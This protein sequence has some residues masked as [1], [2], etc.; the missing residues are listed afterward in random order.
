KIKVL[1]RT[2]FK[3]GYLL[4]VKHFRVKDTLCWLYVFREKKFYTL[5]QQKFQKSNPIRTEKAK[6]LHIF[7]GRSFASHF[8]RYF[9]V[10]SEDLFYDLDYR[11]E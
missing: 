11:G 8:I 5:W 6:S 2:F 9:T 7:F 10:S 3:N 1:V 4:R